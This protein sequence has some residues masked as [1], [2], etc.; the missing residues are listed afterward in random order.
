MGLLVKSGDVI[1]DINTE[2]TELEY[3][4]TNNYLGNNK[5]NLIN[6]IFFKLEKNSIGK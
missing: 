6:R 5:A 3:N 2:I 4:K 1:L